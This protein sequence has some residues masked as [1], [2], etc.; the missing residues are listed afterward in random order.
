M[1]LAYLFKNVYK[2]NEIEDLCSV[3]RP[4]LGMI[5]KNKS[6]GKN[7]YHTWKYARPAGT[8]NTFSTALGMQDQQSSGVQLTTQPSQKYRIFRLD[9]KEAAASLKGDAYAYASTKKNELNDTIDELYTMIDIDLHGAGNGVVAQVT[10]ISSLT[11]TLSSDAFMN[12][13]MVNQKLVNITATPPVDGTLPT[14]G[15]WVGT[16]TGV[17][18]QARKIT[19]DNVTG[20]GG[21]D[22]LAFQGDPIGFSATNFYGTIIG[23]GAW[24]PTADP[25]SN[26]NFL[27]VI[28]R[29]TDK[30]RMSG[31]RTAAAGL[32]TMD[33]VSLNI[34]LVA[35]LGGRPDF[36]GLHPTDWQRMSINLQTQV[37][38]E[39]MKIG[40]Y[41]F[42]VMKVSAAGRTLR[43]FSDPHQQK[44]VA[45][46]YSMEACELYSV[47]DLV[48][49]ADDDGLTAVRDANADAFQIRVRSW[50]Q[51]R[52]FDP[53]AF[54]CVTGI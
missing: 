44:T 14:L 9:A 40:N 24:V 17:D 46:I 18:F 48:E 41:G 23:F 45:R 38:Y 30:A 35:E 42:E 43:F 15:T 21:T 49:L 8:S 50:P 54:G 26:D 25:A 16:V 20:L 36:V 37:R 39:D 13:F 12:R 1:A 34:A 29:T 52:V 2:P 4:L 31:I 19:V 3:D 33:A 7:M 47:A 53:H 32:T 51:L 22:W 11:L 10:N 6:G 5:P 27:G 28:N